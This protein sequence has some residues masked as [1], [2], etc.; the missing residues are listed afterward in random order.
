M[1]AVLILISHDH[2]LAIAKRLHVIHGFILLLVLQSDN[3]DKVVDFL[4][5][6]DLLLVGLPH[7]QHLTLDGLELSEKKERIKAKGIEE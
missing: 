1:G 5:L 3:L 2:D 7:V 6:H 4:V